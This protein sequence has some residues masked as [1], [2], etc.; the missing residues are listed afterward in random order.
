MDPI[1]SNKRTDNYY[2]TV[3]KPP[4]QPEKEPGIGISLSC[5]VVLPK[6]SLLLEVKADIMGNVTFP[7]FF[8][9]LLFFFFFSLS[10]SISFS[11]SS[12]IFLL[13]SSFQ[14]HDDEE[15]NS[16]GGSITLGGDTDLGN[17]VQ[18]NKIGTLPLDTIIGNLPEAVYTQ[19]YTR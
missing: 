18:I 8:P 19:N 16:I 2:L 11:F 17:K 15:S 12:L 5:F 6:G 3:S 13:S 1:K 14:N 10:L 4:L 9:F 7:L